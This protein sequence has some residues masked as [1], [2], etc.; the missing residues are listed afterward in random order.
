MQVLLTTTRSWHLPHT[1]KAL[2]QRG[3]LAGLWMADSNSS[4]LPPSQ[5]VRC[6]PYHLVM[7]PFYHCA[8]QIWSERATYFFQRIYERWLQARL[9][10]PNCPKYQVVQGIT[11][12]CTEAFNRA[13]EV[14]ALKVADCANSHPTTQYGYWQRECDLWCPGEQVPIPR[15]AFARMNRELN[16]ADLIIVQSKFCL[17]SMVLNGIP[18]EKVFINP[19]GVNT[20]LFK[21]RQAVAE[22]PRFICVATICLRKGHQYLFRAFDLVRQKIPQAELICVGEYKRDFRRERP[23]WEG[24]FTHYPQLTHAEI[25]ELL[26]KCTAFVFPSQEEGIGRAQI[27]AMACGLPVIGTHEAG[28]STIISNGDGGFVVQSHDPNSIADAMIR[29]ASDRDLNWRMGEAAFRGA[30]AQNSWQDYGDRLL[31]EYERRLSKK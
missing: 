3:A 11:G 23:R 21:K 4:G 26:P 27:E 1:A 25:A 7:K 29:L 22:K 14:G 19:M 5:Y 12:I 20:A 31:A 17:E 15:S 30:G 6:W 9:E 18:A 28:T 16:R 13:D 8:S 2:S 24:K 10:S